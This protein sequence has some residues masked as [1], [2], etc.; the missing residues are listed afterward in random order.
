M[1]RNPSCLTALLVALAG[2]LFGPGSAVAAAPVAV[3]ESRRIELH[4][5]VHPALRQS[6]DLGAADRAQ[7]FEG[8]T[9]ILKADA[10][11]EAAL[12][13]LLRDQQNPHHPA[14]HHWLTPE[15][16]AARFGAAPAD[17]A[18]L[19]SWLEARGFR[20]R[21]LP[22]GGRSMV[23]SGTLGQLDDAFGTQMHRYRWHG[24]EHLAT[25]RN[26]T[27]PAAFA[28]LVAGFASLHDFRRQ[29]QHRRAASTP[30][31]NRGGTNYLAPGDFATIYDLTNSYASGVTGSGRSI[32]VLGR[33]NIHPVDIINFR[34]LF[35]L[36]SL[37]PTMTVTNT[38][39]TKLP[40]VAADQTESD[41]DLEWAGAV[42]PSAS[43]QFITSRTTAL[44]DGIDLSASYAVANNV[45][46]IVSLSYGS[47]ESTGDI[48]S[49]GDTYYNN[50][51][52]Q[53][54]AQGIS[55]FVSSGDSGAAGCD[56]DSSATASLGTGVNGLCTSAY[57]TCV[58]GTEFVGDLQNPATYWSPTNAGNASALGYI[59]ES[60]WNQSGSVGGSGLYASGGGASLYIAKPA[61]QLATGVPGDGRR[62]VPDV[63]L[64]SSSVH[65]AYLFYTSDGTGSS[66]LLAIGGTS[67]AAPAMAGITALVA[68][69]QGGRV[70]NLNPAL[71]G[72]SEMQAKGGLP[73]FHRITSGNNTVP[74]QTGFAA[75]AG[76]PTYSQASGL[77]SVDGG[78]LLAGWSTYA[79]PGYGLAPSLA[80]LPSGA[81]I[82]SATLTLPA[83]TAWSATIAANPVGWLTV[84]PATGSGS[85]PL[86]LFASANTGSSPRTATLTVDGQTLTVTQAAASGTTNEILSASAPSLTFATSV[87]GLATATQRILVS[88][89]GNTT[90]MIA[91]VTFSGAAAADFS[92]TGSCVGG[93]ALTPGS[94]CYIDV[95]FDPGASGIRSASLLVS[96]SD[97]TAV[98]VAVSG[99]GTGAAPID[100][101]M[102]DG[103]LPAWSYGLLGLALIVIGASHS[104]GHHR[105]PA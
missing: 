86:S 51:W 22:A 28:P 83:T 30:A 89:P 59:G 1:Y 53:A 7:A 12:E 66:T 2:G 20:L 33:T 72:L 60:V 18:T 79:G 4:G 57:A 84:T 43:I 6:D 98:G 103:P 92:A 11:R 85:A 58:G 105:W 45:A 81:F 31:Y 87:V 46:D 54:A 41:L 29:P 35:G 9:L 78:Q 55:V 32:A 91:A 75:S 25:A 24:E 77:G 27:V 82:G 90:L 38:T 5:H 13:Q 39:A 73:V 88:D 94:S 68:Q 47:C 10:P 80:V 69:Q 102:T 63:A 99:T 67:A 61:W 70:G 50:L 16:F 44:T 36:S 56:L 40:F 19:R 15:A 64:A 37:V 104:R 48:L 23:F 96:L 3:D 65:D 62:D 34:A 101:N 21:E 97:G 76:N 71:Y 14:Y 93:L 52:R 95:A 42:A 100:S 49:S 17:I 26:P 74:G 8:V